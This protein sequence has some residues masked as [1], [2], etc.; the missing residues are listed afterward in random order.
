MSVLLITLLLVFEVTLMALALFFNALGL[1]R[2]F[3]PDFIIPAIIS[4]IFGGIGS[5]MYCLR[6]IYLNV[7]VHNRWSTTW[8]PWYFI[9]PFVGLILGGSAYLFIKSGLLL[10][11]T[12]PSAQGLYPI[13]S[14]AFLAGLNVDGFIQRV[15]SIGQ[16]A[17]GISPSAQHRNSEHNKREA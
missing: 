6:A 14:M 13:W 7:C 15:E 5:C 11:C 1:F 12:Q 10:F 3:V 2:Q 9:R 8:L 4:V 17:W 16:R